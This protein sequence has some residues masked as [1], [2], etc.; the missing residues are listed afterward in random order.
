MEINVDQIQE[1]WI[2]SINYII[3]G[4]LSIYTIDLL[5]WSIKK[6]YKK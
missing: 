2:I 5:F 1:A 6:L 4:V 3:I